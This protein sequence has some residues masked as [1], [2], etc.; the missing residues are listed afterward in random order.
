MVASIYS[1]IMSD[2][3]SLKRCYKCVYV[4]QI[5]EKGVVVNRDKKRRRDVLPTLYNIRDR[6]SSP[7]NK[8]LYFVKS[9]TT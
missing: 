9:N 2:H 4:I 6:K 1:G 7:G 5:I 8:C 3:Q